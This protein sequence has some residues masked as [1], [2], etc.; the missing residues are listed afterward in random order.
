MVKYVLYDVIEMEYDEIARCNDLRMLR[1]HIR[2]YVYETD[3]ECMLCYKNVVT[4]E[5]NPIYT[6]W[7]E[8]ESGKL[9]VDITIVK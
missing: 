7:D 2:D 6:E 8:T 1:G 9:T 5:I 4:G 3:N